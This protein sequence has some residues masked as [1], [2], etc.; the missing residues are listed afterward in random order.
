MVVFWTRGVVCRVGAHY[1]LDPF[2]AALG[3]QAQAWSRR[4]FD[5]ES[6]PDEC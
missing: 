2:L 4:F 5:M 6:F 3:L 1:P